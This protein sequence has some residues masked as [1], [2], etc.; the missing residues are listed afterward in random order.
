MNS[1]TNRILKLRRQGKTIAQIK[2]ALNI[3]SNAS[4]YH[5]LNKVGMRPL[6]L[7][8]NELVLLE[9]ILLQVQPTSEF[10]AEACWSILEAIKLSKKRK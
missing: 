8:A 9:S 5:H 7:T 1:M 4:V 6:M 2:V 3:A 10:T